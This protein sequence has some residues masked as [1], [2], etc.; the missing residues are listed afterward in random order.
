M[1]AGLEVRRWEYRREEKIDPIV[2]ITIIFFSL[3]CSLV[4]A[5][6]GQQINIHVLWRHMMGKTNELV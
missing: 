6:Y 3:L 5:K 1:C 4:K 2:I